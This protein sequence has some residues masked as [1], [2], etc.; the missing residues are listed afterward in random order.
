[1]KWKRGDSA[2]GA[3]N[4]LLLVIGRAPWDKSKPRICTDIKV[5]G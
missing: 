5:I 3:E 4:K 1:M 2:A